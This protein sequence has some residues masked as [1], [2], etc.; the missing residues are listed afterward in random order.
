MAFFAKCCEPAPFWLPHK[1]CW[2]WPQVKKP[3]QA[4]VVLWF[5]PHHPKLTNRLVSYID[6]YNVRDTDLSF[7]RYFKELKNLSNSC[8]QRPILFF[9]IFR[10]KWEEKSTWWKVSFFAR[11]QKR[12]RVA[13]WPFWSCLPEI[14]WFGH[15]PFFGA[16]F[17]CFK[18]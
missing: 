7:E 8:G 9:F 10:W 13:I 18:K 2:K 6:F 17:E 12:D 15:L 3:R 11:S 1:V 4:I 5:R 16:F 14:K